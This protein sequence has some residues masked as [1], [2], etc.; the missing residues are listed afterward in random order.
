[1]NRNIILCIAI[2]LCFSSKSVSQNNIAKVDAYLQAYQEKIP[3]PG[4]SI[5]IVEDGQTVFSKGYGQEKQG[6]ST[7]MSANSSLGIGSL[8]RAF[9][10]VGIM[11]LVEGGLVDLDAPVT[12]YLP[13]FTTANKNFSDEITVRMCLSNTTAIPAQFEAVPT[14]NPNESLPKF[15]RSM[16][17][18]Y[19]KRKPGLAYE[20]SDEGYSIAGLIISELSGMRY[21]DYVEEKIFLP[22]GLKKTTTNP[23]KFEALKVLYGHELA[24]SQCIEAKKESI[25]GNLF[26]AGSE[27]KSSAQD[28]GNFANMLLQNGQYK[29]QQFLK[30]GSVEE[31][32]KANISFQGLGTMLGGNGID[33]QCGLGWLEMNIEERTI[34]IQ[35]GN[36]G[37]TAAIVGLNRNRNQGVVMLFNGDVNRLNRFVYPTLENTANNVIHLMNGEPTTDFAITRLDDPY[38][39]ED[40]ELPKEKWDKYL[41]SYFP[42]GEE[43]PFFKDINIEIYENNGQIEL[44]TFKEK[45]LKGHYILQF[46]NETRAVLRNIA[47]PRQ[48]Q[49][50]VF[51]N[52]VIG[53]MFMLGTEFKKRNP[54]LAKKFTTQELVG[55]L[56]KVSF[57]LPQTS[58]VTKSGENALLVNLSPKENKELLVFL[59]ELEGE[60]FTDFVQDLTQQSTIVS[61]GN[62]ITKNLRGGIWTEQTIFLK[63]GEATKQQVFILFQDPTSNKQIQAVV[64]TNFGQFDSE[65]QE[66]IMYFQRSIR[67]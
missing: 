56:G 4:F 20:F 54:A 18:Y 32:F 34:Y 38:D 16:E 57:L 40:F 39:D 42:Y 6:G 22:L 21:V 7:P 49:F 19:V 35:V 5:V 3:I 23:S 51:P 9:T 11:Q 37:T 61:K 17:G 14:L 59:N 62:L 46:T 66:T 53:G 24:L 13:W 8:G 31:I 44:K 60:S 48:I 67:F 25:N 43:S 1:M 12:K 36:T 29:G 27:M 33:I 58:K 41:G 10:T 50:K 45:A 63:T 30:P 2:L 52:G 28:Y 47:Q 55:Q 64:S 15:V 65:L 26:P